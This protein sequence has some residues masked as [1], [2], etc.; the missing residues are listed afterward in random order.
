MSSQRFSIQIMGNVQTCRTEAEISFPGSTEPWAVV[1]EEASGWQAETFGP[2]PVS[3]AL[4]KEAVE[5]ARLRL[6][7]YIHRRGENP[8]AGLSAPGLSLWLM[9]KADG[10]AMG[11]PL[12]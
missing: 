7:Q 12:P 1:W 4:A 8:P 5:A 6:S 3:E 2:A 9:A 10:T 11:R